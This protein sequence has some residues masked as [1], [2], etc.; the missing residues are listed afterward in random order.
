MAFIQV[1]LADGRQNWLRIL[2]K[3]SK[4]TETSTKIRQGSRNWNGFLARLMLKLSFKKRL[5]ESYGIL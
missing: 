1:Y 2:K 5:T 3:H 4:V